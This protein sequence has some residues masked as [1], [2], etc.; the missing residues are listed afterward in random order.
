MKEMSREEL[1]KQTTSISHDGSYHNAK[2]LVVRTAEPKNGRKFRQKWPSLS[3]QTA[4]VYNRHHRPTDKIRWRA[5][6]VL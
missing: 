2:A 3:A 6:F 5:D 1:L 4:N